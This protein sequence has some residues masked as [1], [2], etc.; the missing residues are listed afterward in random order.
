MIYFSPSPLPLPPRGEEVIRAKMCITKDSSPLAGE[1]RSGG[2]YY[3]YFSLV[4]VKRRN[5]CYLEKYLFNKPSK[6]LPWRA[7]SLAISCTLS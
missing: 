7:S 5:C 4:T 3:T 2:Q 1:D 6:P